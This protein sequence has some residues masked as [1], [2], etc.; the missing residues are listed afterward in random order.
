M[1]SHYIRRKHCNYA[2]QVK[3]HLSKQFPQTLPLRQHWT[4]C[5]IRMPVKHYGVIFL[6]LGFRIPRRWRGRG[7]ST[8]VPAK[9]REDW[10]GL[11][12]GRGAPSLGVL[13]IHSSLLRR[14]SR[15]DNYGSVGITTWHIYR[16]VHY[17]RIEL[18]KITHRAQ[19]LSY[20]KSIKL[21]KVGS[22]SVLIKTPKIN[23]KLLCIWLQFVYIL[24]K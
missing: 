2:P 13:V 14:P 5:R 18:I 3:P 17:I 19:L 15:P 10:P 16:Q 22:H 20:S 24:R 7:S 4:V 11:T 6:E 23:Y 1:C 9:T 8:S 12:R 21:S